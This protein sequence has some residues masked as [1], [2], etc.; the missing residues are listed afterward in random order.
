MGEDFPKLP[1]GYFYRITEY[2]L[3]PVVE[4]RRKRLI[5]SGLVSCAE[6]INNPLVNPDM[7]VEERICN[8]ASRAW[9]RAQET[10]EYE[11]TVKAISKKFGDYK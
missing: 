11:E 6:I 8:A 10:F 2:W 5:G 7:S 3:S 1:E 9:L 4:I